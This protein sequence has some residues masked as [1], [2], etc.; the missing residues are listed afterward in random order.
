MRAVILGLFFALTLLAVACGPKRVTVAGREMAEPEANAYAESELARVRALAAAQQPERAAQAFEALASKLG[1][2]APAAEA[3]YEAAVRWRTLKRPDRALVDLSELLTRFP[4]SP[5][6]SDAK[7]QLAL[8]QLEAGRPRDAMQTLSS[9]YDK[10]PVSDRA[11]A[12]R[13]LGD[14]AEAARAWPQA[15]RWRGEAVAQLSGADRDREMARLKEIVE[16]RL[17]QQELVKLR[18]DLPRESPALPVVTWKLAQQHLQLQQLDQAQAA[19]QE[20]IDRWPGEPQAVEARGLLD[21]LAR[22]TQMRPG[23]LG[24]AIPLSGK[25][26]AWGEAIQQAAAVALEGSSLKVVFR[27]TRG[28]PDGAAQAM[29]ALASEEGAMAVIG[30]VANAEAQR[31]ASSAQE[32]GL[33]LISLSKVEGVTDAGPFVF[34]NMLTASAQAHALADFAARRGMRRFALL[35]PNIPYGQ[36]LANAF[37]DEVDGRGGEIRGAETYE[38]DRTTFAPLVKEMVGKLHLDERADYGK[39][40]AELRKTE[41]NPYRLSKAIEKMRRGLDPIVD[42]DAIFI[43]DFAKN[44]AL[45]A[46]AL[47]VEDVVT[48]TCDPRALERIRKSTGRED[49][50][51]VQLLGANGWD[52]PSLVEKVGRYV[53]CAVIVDGFFAASERPETRRFTEEFQRRYQ[54]P[55]TILEASAYDAARLLRLVLERDRPQLRDLVRTGLAAVKDFKGATGDLSFDARREAVKPLF[56]LTVD[57]TGLREMTREE[58]AGPS[59]PG[60]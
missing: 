25:F 22:R 2:A 11:E 1:D 29:E 24:L 15:V 32:L 23:T 9:L 56:F 49:L 3:Y 18:E 6:A 12:A 52:D 5:R 45:I 44:L 13:R 55:P 58:L 30:G 16:S 28:E 26:K 38:P 57:K 59:V 60:S 46:P 35:Y 53:E 47:A 50:R 27:D 54:R 39:M 42:F 48:T 4:L 34:R 37:W 43:P 7:Y 17:P 21:R 40:L 33:P 36:E 41:Q 14:A 8:A 10:L 19:A 31:S 51:P 20:V